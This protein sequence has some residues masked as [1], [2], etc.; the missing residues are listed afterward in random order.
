MAK[1]WNHTN[2]GNRTT[3]YELSWSG[4]G[5][6]LLKASGGRKQT[7][8]LQGKPHE[9]YRM[10]CWLV[11]NRRG[12]RGGLARFRWTGSGGET[13]EIDME[14]AAG[15]GT[16][17]ALLEP[18]E[19][20]SIPEKAVF[21]LQPGH[22]AR[23]MNVSEPQPPAPAPQPPAPVPQMPTPVPQTP[24]R[25]PQPTPAPTSAADAMKI[26]KLE[27]EL[28]SERAKGS[29]LQAQ[30]DHLINVQ[31]T[32]LIAELTQQQS[33]LSAANAGL[34]AKAK[35]QQR[36]IDQEE[37]K[38]TELQA[39]ISRLNSELEEARTQEEILS[40]DCD[41]K[42]DE[43]Q[44]LRRRLQEDEDTIQLIQNDPCAKGL[45][46]AKNLEAAEKALTAAEKRI[47]WIIS[48]REKVNGSVWDAVVSASG[49]GFVP[50]DDELGGASRED[51]EEPEGDDVT[52]GSGGESGGDTSERPERD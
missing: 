29:G 51:Y 48:I 3:I 9:L 8:G 35:G 26:A 5:Q 1:V 6:L 18:P 15:N 17:R 4:H 16:L 27:Q 37:E 52:V 45:P 46:V 44:N 38:R 50:L 11:E 19:H 22:P 13:L 42:K 41:A 10:G 30:L 28:V 31:L 25:A 34:L 20:I 12:S 21:Q 14:E 49:A 47:G 2:F 24:I 43:I 36:F 40:L 7:V 39:R 33:Q 23:L 32:D